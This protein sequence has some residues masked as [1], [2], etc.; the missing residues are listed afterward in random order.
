MSELFLDYEKMAGEYWEK[1][2]SL[3]EEEKQLILEYAR[4]ERIV[5]DIRGR[6]W[7]KD[8]P[9]VRRVCLALARLA[10]PDA[11]EVL[12]V[13]AQSIHA[14]GEDGE[15]IVDVELRTESN[16]TAFLEIQRFHGSFDDSVFFSRWLDRVSVANLTSK[17]TGGKR[18]AVIVLF[19]MEGYENWNRLKSFSKVKYVIYR[20]ERNVIWCEGAEEEE[21]DE[22]L[23]PSRET[24]VIMIVNMSQ[25]S[26]DDSE[27]G[28]ILHDF[29]AS[30]WMD[31]KNEDVRKR[32][33][34]MDESEEDMMYI[35]QAMMMYGAYVE[36]RK[37][38][39]MARILEEKEMALKES[40]K[41]IEEKERE[42]NRLK[43]IISS[44]EMEG[45]A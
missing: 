23:F 2:Q 28:M 18:G 29:Y 32:T 43:A 36:D 17:A 20:N 1:Y 37:D 34:D 45:K 27:I 30:S 24:S 35:S 12:S 41:V 22:E 13:V 26:K 39:E 25:V 44:R 31:M 40:S 21:L 5:D 33:R 7:F 38:K 8:T 4:K 9:S 11:K 14:T 6:Y 42:I 3:P 16:E 15:I 10:F 19:D